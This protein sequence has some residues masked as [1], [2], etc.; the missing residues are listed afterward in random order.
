MPHAYQE[1]TDYYQKMIM[2]G[3]IQS[4][5]TWDQQTMLPA[6]SG[7][8]RAEQLAFIAR[9]QH[10]YMTADA[11][12]SGLAAA[13]NENLSEI[14]QANLQ[15]MNRHYQRCTAI[16]A[17]LSA[18]LIQAK[19]T[20][21]MAWEAAKKDDDFDAVT[22]YLEKLLDLVREEAVAMAQVYD[23]DKYEALY[24]SYHPYGTEADLKDIFSEVENF[25]P[26]LLQEIIE[27]QK[28][29]I[30]YEIDS[31]VDVT[32]Q[33]QFATDMAQLMGF[34]FDKGR[35]DLSTHPFTGGIADDV[36]MTSRYYA[37]NPLYGF[38]AMVHE[39]GHSLYDANFPKKWRH[40]A[41]G[42]S[43]NMG[44][45]VHE[46]QSLIWERQILINPA[47][48]QF[49]A[50]KMKDAFGLSDKVGSAEN[51]YRL[52]AKVEPDFIRTDADE[53]TYPLHVLMRYQLEKA[54]VNGDL[55]VKELS[56][57]WAEKSQKLLGIT[58]END[59]LGCMQDIHWYGGAFGY[60]PCYALGA[61]LAAQMFEHA[62]S[63][64]PNLDADLAQGDY[65]G[66]ST[67]LHDNIHDQGGRYQPDQLIER[68]TGQKLNPQIFEKYLRG[69]YL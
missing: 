7:A 51:L 25:L 43:F 18:A 12:K 26:S 62:Q 40:D 55:S 9:L 65:A 34:D 60:F 61:M 44:M 20:C 2:L 14:E 68:V 36:R 27:K 45:V 69:K 31:E 48:W 30:I 29:Q 33:H 57:A 39:F 63:A 58:P 46:S 6:K 13:S 4:M 17:E 41:I 47:F 28:S 5:L 50:P 67:W 64:L 3:N 21:Q 23:C 32:T 38:A 24:R 54:M 42:Q 22:P 53:V 56:A 66:F 52:T 35:F 15:E 16:D 10:E 59:V 19:S 8:A 49:M 11:M 1:L 37:D